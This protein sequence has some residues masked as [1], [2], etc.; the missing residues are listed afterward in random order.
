M[1]G[2]VKSNGVTF[3]ERLQQIIEKNLANYGWLEGLAPDKLFLAILLDKGSYG[4]L[5]VNSL[6]RDWEVERVIWRIWEAIGTPGPRGLVNICTLTGLCDY[7]SER[8]EIIYGGDLPPVLNTG[9]VVLAALNDR[10][11]YASRLTGLYSVRPID[12][13]NHMVRLP[14]DEEYRPRFTQSS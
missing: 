6:M 14:A 1:E 12:V 10:R 5:I 13:F 3:S 4:S 9:H 11:L 7:L 8:L 2:T